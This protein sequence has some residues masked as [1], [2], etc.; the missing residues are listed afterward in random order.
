MFKEIRKLW[1]TGKYNSK[2]ELVEAFC[3]SK[4]IDL[5]SK[6]KYDV[7]TIYVVRRIAENIIQGGSGHFWYS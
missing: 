4:H 1:N 2:R 6:D 5:K 3:E 7:E